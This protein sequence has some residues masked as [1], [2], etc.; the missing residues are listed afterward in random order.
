MPRKLTYPLMVDDFGLQLTRLHRNSGITRQGPVSLEDLAY[1]VSELQTF[2]GAK[3]SA[4]TASIEY[5]LRAIETAL[6]LASPVV[7]PP[8]IS[9]STIAI[10]DQYQASFIWLATTAGYDVY[11]RHIYS[12]LSDPA[13]DYQ[14]FAR[15]CKWDTVGLNWLNVELEVTRYPNHL[16]IVPADDYVTVEWRTLGS[17]LVATNSRREGGT[18]FNVGTNGNG[19]TFSTVWDRHY[20]ASGDY[21][22]EVVAY[23]ENDVEIECEIRKG[24]N[25]L[26]FVPAAEAEVVIWK[27]T[28]YT[29]GGV[30][31]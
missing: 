25:V 3:Q 19:V 30:T 21:T 16:H 13:G 22:A 12:S 20:D 7:T 9:E 11:F 29:Q 6:G 10:A 24:H 8:T 18:L 27:A 5:R 17:L 28:G 26:N 15:G 4:D 14:A 2:L 1:A 23:D 31:A